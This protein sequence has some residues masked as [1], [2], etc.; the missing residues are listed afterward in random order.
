MRG[1]R[2]GAGARGG[3]AAS[4][5]DRHRADPPTGDSAVFAGRC[6]RADC[7]LQRAPAGS[8][9]RGDERG[10]PGAALGRAH[11]AARPPR[12]RPPRG[13]AAPAGRA[14]PR[15]TGGAARTA[16][17]RRGRRS[18][19]A[20]PRRAPARTAAPAARREDL[21]GG[22][23]MSPASSARTR[24]RRQRAGP[25]PGPARNTT[26]GA[27]QLGAP[28]H[29][30]FQVQVS[31]VAAPP[32]PAAAADLDHG[33]V[34][35]WLKIRIEMFVLPRSGPAPSAR[36]RPGRSGRAPRRRARRRS[37][38]GSAG[39]AG[40][41][42]EDAV[43]G[44]TAVTGSPRRRRAPSAPPRPRARRPP[45]ARPGP[46]AR[47]RPD[48]GGGRGDRRR[49]LAAGDG[50]AGG[51]GSLAGGGGST[52]SGCSRRARPRRRRRGAA[53][54]PS[55]APAGTGAGSAGAGGAICVT[56][57]LLSPATCVM[58]PRRPPGPL[59]RR[60]SAGRRRHSGRDV[61]AVILRWYRVVKRIC[62]RRTHRQG[63]ARRPARRWPASVRG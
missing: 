34:V 32:P 56:G 44:A 22:S 1:R 17:R 33:S 53:A 4:G 41:G 46:A 3:D 36:R 40:A 26:S 7:A 8:R 31:S 5:R 48:A 37:P 55:P 24:R 10:R 38:G 51:A 20:P 61:S 29:V 45:A 12:C 60:C 52:A 30:Q 9:P 27:G 11:V 6:H 49:S 28:D 39:A 15:R 14:R 50:A 13:R 25:V 57:S 54:A 63:G 18:R 43:A 2:T 19:P 23:T 21:V 62:G 16:A 42:G 58:L 47:G 35:T 59:Q